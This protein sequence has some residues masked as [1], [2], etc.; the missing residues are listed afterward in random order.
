VNK[1]MKPN[2]E[3]FGCSVNKTRMCMFG[4]K[5]TVPKNVTERFN[6]V[7]KKV[8]AREMEIEEA[9]VYLGN[10]GDSVERVLMNHSLIVMEE[11]DDY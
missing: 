7:M 3:T 5:E 4:I 8:K 6:V 10:F 2:E 1:A 11:S 9:K